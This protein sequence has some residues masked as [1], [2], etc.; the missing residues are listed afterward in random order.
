MKKTLN[1]NQLAFMKKDEELEESK[2]I[3]TN[4]KKE[5]KQKNVNLKS[6]ISDN[7]KALSEKNEDQ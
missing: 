5:L 6:Q 1:L 4:E 2:Q 7:N 3:L